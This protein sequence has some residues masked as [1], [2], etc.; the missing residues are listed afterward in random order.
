M[1][2]EKNGVGVKSLEKRENCS[3]LPS[4]SLRLRWGEIIKSRWSREKV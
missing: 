4:E 1:K 3:E 2:E